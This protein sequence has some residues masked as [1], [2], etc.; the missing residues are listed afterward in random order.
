MML[1][2]K[3]FAAALLSLLAHAAPPT[4]NREFCAEMYD[5]TVSNGSVVENL[6]FNY[7]MCVSATAVSW[8]R[9]DA[10][11]G[12]LVFNGTHLI[13]LSYNGRLGKHCSCDPSHTAKPLDALPFTLLSVPED[14]VAQGAR[15]VD[16]VDVTLWTSTEA[17]DPV[18]GTPATALSFYV[19]GEDR[20]VR[21]AADAADDG[22]VTVNDFVARGGYSATVPAGAFAAPCAC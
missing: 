17:A 20:L 1:P 11:K 9:V 22:T 6:V 13:T 15:T 12:E 14:A 8:K 19:D 5:F 2:R 10:A 21:R 7:T 18:A 16:G 4:P 3:T